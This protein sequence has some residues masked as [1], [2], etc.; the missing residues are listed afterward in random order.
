VGPHAQARE[1][2]RLEAMHQPADDFRALRRVLRD[3]GGGCSRFPPAQPAVLDRADLRLEPPSN[4]APSFAREVGRGRANRCV[5][6]RREHGPHEELVC[7]VLWRRRYGVCALRRL[8]GVEPDQAWK[9]TAP[10]R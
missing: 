5:L 4:V 6:H 8:G 3:I 7:E 2:A 10:R 9:C 1:I